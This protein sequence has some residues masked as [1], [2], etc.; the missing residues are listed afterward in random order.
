MASLA[1]IVA[2]MFM[3]VLISGPLSALFRFFK[4]R[5]LAILFGLFAIVIGF[6]WCSVTPFPVSLIGGF[7]AIL[8]AWGVS[9]K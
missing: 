8:G 3:L 2:I 6:Y 9:T 4:F 5:I 7:S 1:L